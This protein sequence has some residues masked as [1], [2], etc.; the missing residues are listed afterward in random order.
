MIP[1]EISLNKFKFQSQYYVTGHFDF[2]IEV[3]YEDNSKDTIFRRYSEIRALYKTLILKCPGCLIPNIPSKTIWLQINYEQQQQINERMEGIREFLSHLTKHKILRK[4]KEVIYFFSK[5]YKRMSDNNSSSSNYKSK[6]NNKDDSD[7]EIDIPNNFDSDRKNNIKDQNEKDEDNNDSNDEIEPLKEF[8]EEY[9][10]KNKGILTKGKKLIGNMY[11]YLKSYTG[12]S[13]KNEEEGE[14]NNNNN[15][16]CNLSNSYYKKLS[17]EDE[18]FIKKKNKALGED[19]EINDYN[20]KI[21][22]L[23]DG[24][25]NIIQNF[26]KLISINNRK[27]QA[28]E[29]IVNNDKNYKNYIKEKKEGKNSFSSVDEE[30]ENK[31]N[32]INNHKSNI[33]KMSD[34]CK[35][36][37]DYWNKKIEE[38]LT[39]IKKYQI[40]L[41]GLLDIYSRKKD[42]LNFLGR[43]HSQ[44]GEI[45]KQ[46][47]NNIISSNIANNK[48]D[49]LEKNI[50]HEIKFIKKMNKDLKYE[51]EKYKKNQEDIYIYVNS[52]F[53]VK[54]NIIKVTIEK[55]N[56]ENLEEA[57]DEDYNDNDEKQKAKNNEKKNKTKA[58]EYVDENKGDDF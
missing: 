55:L 43:L 58:K 49:E 13:N 38:N 29:N 53:K 3:K 8:V 19:F 4:N 22:R 11:N 23:N 35:I 27:I 32:I 52:L 51:I 30:E 33:L 2:E 9:N 17:K 24:V 34:N 44:K 16:A 28:L 46:K 10:N 1:K 18:E 41:Q 25:Q 37:K 6:N 47:E 15:N 20:D 26:E 7:D 57:K 50:N 31:N 42:H 39:N 36:K 5:N 12:S 45:E 14:E 56:K 21:N 48:L 40:L 54:A